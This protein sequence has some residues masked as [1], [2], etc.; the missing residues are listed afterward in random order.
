MSRFFDSSKGADRSIP[1][2][3]LAGPT[4]SGKT[5]LS[6]E[7]AT[8]IS[9]EIVNADSMQVY[10]YMEI[11]TAKPTLEQRQTVPHHLIDVADPDEPFDAA[12]YLHLARPVIEDI[13]K[14]GRVPLVVGG[15][16][17]Y[18]RVLT[19]GLCPGPSS[20]PELKKKLIADEKSKGLG[21]L[22]CDLGGSTPNRRQESIQTTG[23]EFFGRWRFLA[24]PAFLYPLCRRTMGSRSSF[25]PRSRSL[26]TGSDGNSTNG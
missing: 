21:Q 1:L 17:L 11:G 8:R 26:S 22:Y 18:M 14:R 9:A 6:I 15:T 10:R 24:L 12:R 25:S 2:V 7:L 16:G 19:R 3:L 20:D 23:S 13:R 4:A 5:S